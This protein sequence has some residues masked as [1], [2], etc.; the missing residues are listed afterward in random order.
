[1]PHPVTK[2]KPQRVNILL[3]IIIQD[4]ALHLQKNYAV[5]ISFFHYSDH[6]HPHY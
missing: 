4:L 3:F 6:R 5:E 1:M 2:T